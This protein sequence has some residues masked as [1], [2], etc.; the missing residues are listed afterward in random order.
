MTHPLL[1]SPQTPVTAPPDVVAESRSS[2]R[3][4]VGLTTAAWVPFE[5]AERAGMI[6][7]GLLSPLLGDI[8]LPTLAPAT[9]RARAEALRAVLPEALVAAGVLHRTTA[10]W[11]LSC[12]PAPQRLQL[13]VHRDRRTTMRPVLGAVGRVSWEVR[14]LVH[15]PQDVDR[16]HGV[17]T[18][19][20]LRTAADLAC[21][22]DETAW[23]PLCTLL[24]A[25]HLGVD[26]AEVVE[27]LR[28]RTRLPGRHRGVAIV[29]RACRALELAV[30][31]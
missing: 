4:H 17:A 10:A 27:L 3:A 7:D 14:Q 25:P 23:R 15:E 31:R 13:M 2:L 20:P 12:A 18:T 29:R 5:A 6:R 11:F 30:P 24:G 21:W 26:P 28:R 1:R 8:C 19:T 22:E 16:F 9:R